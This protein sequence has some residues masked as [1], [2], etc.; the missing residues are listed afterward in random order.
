[1]A[2]FLQLCIGVVNI[3]VYFLKRLGLDCIINSKLPVARMG[4]TFCSSES[5]SLVVFILIYFLF[6]LFDFH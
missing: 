2:V 1:M 6:V 4:T 5:C 3:N